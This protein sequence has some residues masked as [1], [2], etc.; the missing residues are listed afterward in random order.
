MNSAEDGIGRSRPDDS[1][2]SGDEAASTD[3]PWPESVECPFCGERET[4]LHAPFGGLLSV[5]QYYCRRCRTVFDW[6]KWE[7]RT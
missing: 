3:S 6:M 2:R 1:R 4:H 5:A 7:P